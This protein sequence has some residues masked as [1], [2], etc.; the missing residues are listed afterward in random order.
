[1][2]TLTVS[3][4]LSIFLGFNPKF[5]TPQQ[6]KEL[7]KAK[8]GANSSMAGNLTPA[9][10]AQLELNQITCLYQSNIDP[11]EDISSYFTSAAMF[12][13]ML[14]QV[15]QKYLACWNSNLEV[16]YHG[17][18]LYLYALSFVLVSKV[19]STTSV[20]ID[21]NISA[22]HYLILKKGL[23]SALQ[24]ISIMTD[25]SLSS[26]PTTTNYPARLL[27][28]HPK[29]Y[30]TH[31]Y[32]AVMFIFRAL[33]GSD[34]AIVLPQNRKSIVS[35]L[36]EALKIFRSFPLHRDHARAAI[37]IPF[38]VHILRERSQNRLASGSLLIS[39]PHSL[40][41]DNRHGASLLFDCAFHVWEERNHIIT[42]AVTNPDLLEGRSEKLKD[43]QHLSQKEVSSWKTLSEQ[44][45]EYLPDT[46]KPSP[47][48]PLPP[49]SILLPQSE[50]MR[51]QGSFNSMNDASTDWGWSD[52][53]QDI[54]DC[55]IS[56]ELPPV[57]PVMQSVQ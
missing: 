36:Q 28:F 10:E 37:N 16:I 56:F 25:I 51:A 38:L 6:F 44:Y 47:F 8:D 41:V 7:E 26:S 23:G 1:M 52:F 3:S 55:G 17:S 32:F 15:K 43:H 27:T 54:A 49:D 42:P 30:F 33:V 29:N 35:A 45:P 13:S 14:N 53:D 2:A 18:K 57:P 46:P 39:R 5:S 19:P 12:D 21:T 24:L 31:L 20:P 40:V 11:D 48:P 22:Q 50:E 4:R 34:H 9:L